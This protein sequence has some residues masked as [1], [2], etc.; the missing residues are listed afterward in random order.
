M[1]R[2]LHRA[3]RR[4]RGR[5]GLAPRRLSLL[6]LACLLAIP[7]EQP[8]AQ[9][10]RRSTARRAAAAARP[11][12]KATTP[13]S[14][15]ALG[16]DLAAQI[17]Q[18]TRSGSWGVLVVSLTR[19]DTLYR[20]NADQLLMP[21]STMKLFTGALALE[22]FG[23]EHRFETTVL[24]DG[25]IGADGTLRGNLVLRGA[26]DPGLAARFY[27]GSASGA[28]DQLADLVARA[29]IR[30]VTGDV[31][32]D[33]SR[34]D[35]KLIPDGWE[36]RDLDAGYAARVSALSL[37]E[38]LVWIAVGP[39][40]SG[41]AASVAL[42]PTT[43]GIPLRNAVRT[44]AGS[45]ARVIV[46]RGT[47]GGME[48]RGWIGARSPVRRY[49]MVVEEPAR[50]ATG[51]FAEAL[52]RRGVSVDGTVRLGLAPLSAEPIAALASPPLEQLV[53]VMERES[54]NHYAELLFRNVARDVDPTRPGSVESARAA[55]RDF[56]VRKVGARADA[57]RATDGSG[58]SSLNQVTPRA[59]VQLLAYAHRAPWGTAFHASLPVAGESELLRHRM[60]ATPAHGNLHAKTGTTNEVISLAGYTTAENGEV[61]AFALVYN[62]TDRWMARATID[63][64]G[65]TI[66]GFA[67]S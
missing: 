40:R 3:L 14:A 44:R 12:P 67:R 13:R 4:P 6:L 10:R 25:S 50:F 43:S 15:D 47:D 63:A 65:T 2:T 54:I 33:A 59:L 24:R 29:G 11:T 1:R 16:A 17:G 20:L 62:G 48:V 28:V 21:A 26:G 46:R 37:N 7:A 38:N 51:A 55:L 36:P 64:M 53:S 32:G 9:S 34:F 56:L 18:G 60:R 8:E 58:L 39:G 30:R 57:V 31:V 5:A 49:L 45:G 22:R 61:L 19:G 66:S 23:P 52:R 42:E 27:Q 41:R 35:G